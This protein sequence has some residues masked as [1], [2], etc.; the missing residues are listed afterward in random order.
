MK[1]R[2]LLKAAGLVPLVGVPEG[3]PVKPSVF[4]AKDI[5][6]AVE[7]LRKNNVPPGADGKY[8]MFLSPKILA[9]MTDAEREA[10]GL[11]KGGETSLEKPCPPKPNQPPS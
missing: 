3:A 5:L 1:R 7:T 6:G 9:G 2:G 8:Q 11:P 4:G 10:L